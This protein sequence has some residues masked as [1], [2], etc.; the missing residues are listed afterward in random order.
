MSDATLWHSSNNRFGDVTAFQCPP[1][2]PKG[3]QKIRELQKT[4]Y[5]SHWDAWPKKGRSPCG[6]HYVGEKSSLLPKKQV[7]MWRKTAYVLMNLSPKPEIGT[8]SEA[9]PCIK[10]KMCGG[11]CWKS[12]TQSRCKHGNHR[13]SAAVEFW[14]MENCQGSGDFSDECPTAVLGEPLRLFHAGLAVLAFERL[15]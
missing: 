12:L 14:P 5:Q 8:L 3:R 4:T 6:G 2:T 11:G 7:L 10:G 1:L 9:T 13:N 15:Q